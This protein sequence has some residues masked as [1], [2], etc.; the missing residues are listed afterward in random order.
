MFIDADVGGSVTLEDFERV[1]KTSCN[2][3]TQAQSQPLLCLDL[4]VIV[5]LL[6][7]GFK[8][9]EKTE[10]MVMKFIQNIE[11]SWTLGAAFPLISANM[12]NR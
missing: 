5:A 9:E 3:P 8:F 7:D 10:M 2:D 12:V 11:L 1:A 4:S 6:R